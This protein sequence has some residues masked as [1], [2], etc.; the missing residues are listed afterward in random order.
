VS[1]GPDKGRDE[2]VFVFAQHTSH[3]IAKQ[4]TVPIKQDFIPS[5]QAKPEAGERA[6][7]CPLSGVGMYRWWERRGGTVRRVKRARR[8]HLS[9]SPKLEPVRKG[10][11][12]RVQIIQPNGSMRYFGRFTSEK[13]ARE[14]IT[15]HAGLM[16]PDNGD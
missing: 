1:G 5:H 12:W 11:M 14:W 13:R 10:R 16:V 6:Q 15:R 9:I 7:S 2:I 3:G 8:S 4:L